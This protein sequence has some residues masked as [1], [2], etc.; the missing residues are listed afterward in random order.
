M[1]RSALASRA[2]GQEGEWIMIEAKRGQLQL[3]VRGQDGENTS[4]SAI[5]QRPCRPRNLRLFKVWLP[6]GSVARVC[7]PILS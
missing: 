5:R 6:T 7:R 2:V 3:P 1:L 4:S